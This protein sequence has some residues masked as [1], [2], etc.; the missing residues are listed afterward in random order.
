VKDKIDVG[1]IGCGGHSW[2]NVL[3]A[4]QW[5]PVNLVAT[6]DL[7]EEK[8]KRAA[9]QFGALK[10]YTN[11]LEMMSQEKLDGVFIVAGYSAEC[12]TRHAGLA[13]DA[14]KAGCHAWI[15]K[16]PASSVAEVRDM[17]RVSKE[18]GKFVL[19]GFKKCFY[20]S[21]EKAKEIAERRDFG[22]PASIYVRY[23]MSLP[24]EEE[25]LQKKGMHVVLDHIPHPGSLLRL[26]MG[27]IDHIYIED[28]RMNGGAMIT[29]GFKSGAVGLLHLTA[30]QSGVSPLERLEVIG[31]G[32]N[33][34]IDNG[35]KLTY[36]RPG[37]RGPYGGAPSYI[38][39]DE[40]APIYW[41]P[42]FSLA[43]LYNK[44]L[45]LEGF[46]GEVSYFAECVLKNKAPK[47]CGLDYALEVTKLYE[48]LCSPSR[49]V[50]K[51]E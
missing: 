25:R 33:V 35:I 28:E 13:I 9:R 29:V 47:K 24:P 45:F 7:D 17:M 19:V 44:G 22:T 38:G 14:M 4:L 18:T 37:N 51:L 43:V 15:E 40:A 2:R 21:V 11:H 27:E 42:E 30:G 16:P 23:P 50:I 31:K 34:V 10:Y 8:A 36:Y 32:A 6:C 39:P 41:E 5:A 26:F 46:A 1:F 12:V 49:Q 48:A 20:P 3:P